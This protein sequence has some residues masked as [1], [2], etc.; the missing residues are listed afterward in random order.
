MKTFAAAAF[1]ALATTTEAIG[2]GAHG[3]SKFFDPNTRKAHTN[4]VGT[5]D[6]ADFAPTGNTVI[7]TEMDPQAE[8]EAHKADEGHLLANPTGGR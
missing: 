4:T 7:D 2:L 3:H 8:F 5:T 6:N 1:C